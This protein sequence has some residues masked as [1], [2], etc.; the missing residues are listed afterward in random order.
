VENIK[1]YLVIDDT[2]YETEIPEGY[3]RKVKKESAGKKEIRA[4]I[5]GVISDVKVKKGQMLK[6]G[7]V[8][9]ILEAMKM[10]NLV[11]TE[12]DGR[13]AEILVSAGDRVAKGQL[14]IKLD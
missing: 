7:H 13:V 8:V 12:T 9:V 4:I 14:I 10:Q 5:P 11:E 3:I 6:E 1:K 2:G